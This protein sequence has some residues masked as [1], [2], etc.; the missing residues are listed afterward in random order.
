MIG[1]GAIMPEVIAAAGL[2]ADEGVNAG[3]LCLT[4]PDLVFRSF[5]Q[6]ARRTPGRGS[7]IIDQLS[8]RTTRRRS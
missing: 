3:V 1:V 7:N 2:L 4:S 5:Q 8:R 6:R